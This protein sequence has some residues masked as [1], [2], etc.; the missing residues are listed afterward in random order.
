MANR[1][2]NPAEIVSPLR[3]VAVLMG[4]G[5]SRL[6]AIR[7]VGVVEQIN[8]AGGSNR[9]ESAEGAEAPSAASL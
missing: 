4:L 6:D 9:V 5:L 8:T 3:Q 7:R 2:A 1:R